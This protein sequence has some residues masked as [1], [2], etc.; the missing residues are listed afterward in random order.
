MCF[1]I[2]LTSIVILFK[3]FVP[4]LRVLVHCDKGLLSVTRTSGRMNYFFLS[5]TIVNNDSFRTRH[6]E[7]R[8]RA[9][10]FL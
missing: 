3:E 9:L 10:A 2:R 5:V 1:F 7:K 4:K 6:F 8:L